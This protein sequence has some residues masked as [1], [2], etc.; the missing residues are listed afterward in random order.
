[1]RAKICGVNTVRKRLTDDSVRVYYYHRDTGTRLDGKPGS[2]EF[3]A[4]YVIR[5]IEQRAHRH[6]GERGADRLLHRRVG[7]MKLANAVPLRGV[8]AEIGL[9]RLRALRSHRE[10][11]SRSRASVASSGSRRETSSRASVAAAAESARRK[12]AQEPSR[13][14]S[15]SP[16]SAS[17]R[18]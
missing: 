1:M 9:R 7:D 13:K 6:I 11:R 12:K 14:R 8:A 5:E 18:R 4:A 17:S 15:T 16:A 10:R 2:P 3:I